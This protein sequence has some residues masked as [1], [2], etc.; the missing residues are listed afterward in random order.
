MVTRMVG[1]RMHDIPMD[2][3][4]MARVEDVRRAADLPSSRD[5]VVQQPDGTNRILSRRGKVYVGPHT[6][7]FDAPRAT[8]G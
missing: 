1:G 4:E 8:R 3:D 5:L 2:D 6:Q 7:F